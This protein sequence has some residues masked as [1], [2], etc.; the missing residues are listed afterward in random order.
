MSLKRLLLLGAGVA[1]LAGCSEKP[2]AD[3]PLTEEAALMIRGQQKARM[4]VGCHGPR[5]ISRVASYPSIAGQSSDYLHEQLHAFRNGERHDPMM[6]SI[7]RNL[8]DEDIAALAHYYA[9]LPAAE[10]ANP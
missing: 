7:A 5:G 1:A 9:G 10:A 4:C 8:S 6:S 3:T 2:P